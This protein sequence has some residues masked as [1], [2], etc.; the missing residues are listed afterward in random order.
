[1]KL[2]LRIYRSVLYPPGT[3]KQKYRELYLALLWQNASDEPMEE[4]QRSYERQ[5]SMNYF[6]QVRGLIDC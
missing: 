5:I 3:P 2:T 4:D 6:S 1:M